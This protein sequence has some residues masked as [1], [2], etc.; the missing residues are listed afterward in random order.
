MIGPVPLAQQGAVS[1]TSAVVAVLIWVGVLIVLAIVTGLIL[2]TLRS[3]LFGPGQN[4]GQELTVM[5]SLQRLRDRG[6]LSENEFQRT[7]E[8]LLGSALTER[9]EMPDRNP[10]PKT[11]HRKRDTTQNTDPPGHGIDIH[12]GGSGGS[13]HELRAEPGYDLAGDPLPRPGQDSAGESG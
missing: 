3:R 2:V 10:D 9:S 8:S 13:G 5:E 6:E 11:A 4:T 7:R 1:D 12:A